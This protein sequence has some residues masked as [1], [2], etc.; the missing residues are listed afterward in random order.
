MHSDADECTDRGQGLNNAVKDASEVVDALTGVYKEHSPLK[1]V[2]DAY[3]A[4]MIPRGATE[5]RLSRE[6]AEK[7]TDAKYEDDITRLG[8][9]RPDA[10]I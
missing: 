6:L 9:N 3:E 1:D 8:L 2:I 5:V 7:R 4:E 10:R